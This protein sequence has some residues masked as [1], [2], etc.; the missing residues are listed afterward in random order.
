MMFLPLK[1][2]FAEFFDLLS[3]VAQYQLIVTGVSLCIG[4]LFSWRAWR[5]TIHPWLHPDEPL[6]VP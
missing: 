4:A 5:F 2:L 6:E 3:H 1:L